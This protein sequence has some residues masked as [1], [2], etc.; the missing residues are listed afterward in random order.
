MDA[1][2]ETEEVIFDAWRVLLYIESLD[3]SPLPDD[4]I[5]RALEEAATPVRIRSLDQARRR[6]PAGTR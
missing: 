5:I 2:L 4:E 1:D 6:A 3:E